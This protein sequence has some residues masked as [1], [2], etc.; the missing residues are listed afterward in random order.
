M[1]RIIF[2]RHCNII[3][4]SVICVWFT[5]SCTTPDNYGYNG[6][7]YNH[8][9]SPSANYTTP[10]PAKQNHPQVIREKTYSFTDTGAT[11][12]NFHQDYSQTVQRNRERSINEYLRSCGMWGSTVQDL[13]DQLRVSIGTADRQLVQLRNKIIIAGGRPE[14]NSNYMAVKACRDNLVNKL[15]AL[16]DRIMNAIISKAT[17]DA[18]KRLIW[19]EEDK[20]AA[21]AAISNLEQ[22]IERQNNENQNL[23]RQSNW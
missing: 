7:S 21:N 8:Y 12:A 5:N 17:G 23:L 19:R 10:A 16:D 14:A 15:K 11:G 3:I 4:L 18:A 2:I 20:A 22:A 1:K 6:Y 13:R 9:Q